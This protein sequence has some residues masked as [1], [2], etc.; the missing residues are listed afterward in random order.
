MVHFLFCCRSVDHETTKTTHQFY[1][2]LF[3]QL[4]AIRFMYVYIYF[5]PELK[6]HEG[7]GYKTARLRL[8]L[9]VFPQMTAKNQ[10]KSQ[11]FKCVKI[12]NVKPTIQFFGQ[13]APLPERQY[14]WQFLQWSC[15]LPTVS[16]KPLYSSS[17][18]NSY[19]FT[20][21]NLL[22][23]LLP[24]GNFT[25]IGYTFQFKQL[26]QI[27]IQKYFNFIISEYPNTLARY[28]YIQYY[29]QI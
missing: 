19:E 17:E 28:Y 2:R 7:Q 21:K 23:F 14:Y 22:P 10:R 27:I 8:C 11:S 12:V 25:Q 20:Y 16:H 3:N 26:E 4:Q 29:I 5:M 18:P 24:Y 6:G 1:H 13:Y 9:C 15:S